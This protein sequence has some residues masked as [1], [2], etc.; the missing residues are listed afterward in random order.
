ME[1]KWWQELKSHTTR[2]KQ[3]DRGFKPQ[4]ELLEARCL[5]DAGFRTIT[6]Y[7][8]NVANPTEGQAGTDL[9]RISPV[10]YADGVSTP[11]QPNTL[12]ARQISND[13]NNQS[14]PIFSGADNLGVYAKTPQSQRK[15]CRSCGGH[16]FTDHPSVGLID[17]YA[18]VIPELV[19]EPAVHVHY[20][21]A[22]CA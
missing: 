4:L 9:I 5:L 15:W 17:V 18:A 13:L 10:A 22:V 20:Q 8:N 6:G 19:F 2:G 21:E 3:R 12:T 14:D 16:V 11:S 1:R 7:G